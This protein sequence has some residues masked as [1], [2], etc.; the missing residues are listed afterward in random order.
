MEKPQPNHESTENGE[1]PPADGFF[2]PDFCNVRM[3]FA[4][5]LIAELLAIVITLSPLE[6][7]S[8]R[9]EDLGVI[10]LFIQWVAL[11]S[12]GVLCIVRPWLRKLSVNIAATAGYIVLIIT[13]T[14]VSEVTYWTLQWMTADPR[15]STG[16]YSDFL[17]RNLGISAIVSA[18]ALRYFYVQHQWAQNLEAKSQA[19]IQALQSRIRPHFLFNSLNTIASLTR[20]NP[21]LAEAATEDLADLFRGT[22]ADSSYEVRLKDEWELAKRYLH[23]EE[24]RMGD[25]L[26]VEWNVEALPENALIPQLTLQPLLENAIYHGIEHIRDGGTIVINGKLEKNIITISIVN[27]MPEYTQPLERASNKMAQENIKQRLS[28]LYGHQGRL[29]VSQTGTQ[30]ELTIRFPYVQKRL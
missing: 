27:P 7:A 9:W 23:I 29:L 25:R 13:T 24:L 15:V 8:N 14:L 28:A 4:V 11:I 21:E 6:T 20:S 1:S 2:L 30:Y 12:A 5:I 18:V 22:L 19:R 3:V 26:K 17:L 10:S 16:W